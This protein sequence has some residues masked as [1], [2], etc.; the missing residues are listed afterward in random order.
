[1]RTRRICKQERLLCLKF[2]GRQAVI[3][4]EL[5]LMSGET[6]HPDPVSERPN[7]MLKDSAVQQPEGDISYIC[8]CF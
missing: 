1:M 8:A 4:S 7:S 6:F 5:I 3:S 2:S